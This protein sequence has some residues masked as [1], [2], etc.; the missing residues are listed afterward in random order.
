MT[1]RPRERASLTRYSKFG[2]S[3]GAPPV[4]STTGISWRRSTS[5][6]SSAVSRVMISL[7]VGPASTWQCRQVW[8][9]S[10]PTLTC[11]VSIPLARSGHW[12]IPASLSSNDIMGGFPPLPDHPGGKTRFQEDPARALVRKLP[13]AMLPQ[14]MAGK[15]SNSEMQGKNQSDSPGRTGTREIHDGVG[16]AALALER[17]A[18][19]A[20]EEVSSKGCGEG[21]CSPPPPAQS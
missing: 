4:M 19:Q 5:T 21:H 8:L 12:L 9:H 11:R 17:G 18:E 3:S 1:R 7:R 20:V 16:D 2:F 14:V 15:K 10:F 13:Q 6:T